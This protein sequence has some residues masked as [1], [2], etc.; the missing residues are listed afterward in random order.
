MLTTP[1]SEA[2]TR[3][4][5][6]ECLKNYSKNY[7]FR[8][9]YSAVGQ[10]PPD[11]KNASRNLYRRSLSHQ[12]LNSLT[13]IELH[14]FAESVSVR[15]RKLNDAIKG[16]GKLKALGFLRSRH[17][18]TNSTQLFL[19]HTSAALARLFTC[20]TPQK[21]QKKSCSALDG[22]ENFSPPHYLIFRSSQRMA[23]EKK[24][25]NY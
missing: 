5:F 17:T 18:T 21:I 1:E 22:K 20:C 14:R 8:I 16:H 4:N 9:L 23:N 6:R 15:T 3:E 11:R 24:F 10:N 2:N 12:P 13:P 7:F 25:V 19:T